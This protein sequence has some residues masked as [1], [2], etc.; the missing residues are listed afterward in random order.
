MEAMEEKII[1]W[2]EKKELND[3]TEMIQSSMQ[4]SSDGLNLDTNGYQQQL[5]LQQEHSMQPINVRPK[6]FGY[7]IVYDVAAKYG[8]GDVRKKFSQSDEKETFERK[9]VKDSNNYRKDS[10]AHL[11][12]PRVVSDSNVGKN[13]GL[14]NKS[15]R[16]NVTSLQVAIEVVF[17]N[18]DKDALQRAC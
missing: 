10:R 9:V 12:G 1:E 2:L 16:P 7:P 18:M 8:L 14:T 15:R 4:Q 5:Y 13:I 11:G 17:I 6:L 3:L